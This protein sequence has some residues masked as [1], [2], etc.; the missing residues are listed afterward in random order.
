MK[1]VDLYTPILHDLVRRVSPWHMFVGGPSFPEK[2]LY[3]P[4]EKFDSLTKTEVKYNDGGHI[5]SI[6]GVNKDGEEAFIE[7]K[8]DDSNSEFIK[9]SAILKKNDLI[10]LEITEWLIDDTLNLTFRTPQ[11]TDY[12]IDF[13]FKQLDNNQ[14]KYDIKIVVNGKTLQGID[15]GTTKIPEIAL[16]FAEE[17]SAMDSDLTIAALN[18]VFSGI[19]VMHAYSEDILYHT[20]DIFN[21]NV[22]AAT[23]SDI[24]GPVVT[25]V[26]FIISCV[27]IYFYFNR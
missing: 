10:Q 16:E 3:N 11:N 1:Q 26:V 8:V 27:F 5:K 22:K 2:P 17:I 13:Y 7:F 15:T 23:Y 4:D 25:I 12:D 9:V 24:K 20:R 19:L 14:G 21:L 18:T 6:S